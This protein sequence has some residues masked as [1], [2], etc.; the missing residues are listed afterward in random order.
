M[1]EPITTHG[2][3]GL[4]RLAAVLA[5]DPALAALVSALAE[6]ANTIEDAIQ[7]MQ[8]LRSV[9]TAG[10]SQLDDIG[11]LIGQARLS[12]EA[13]AVMRR[14]IRARILLNKSRGTV[15]DVITCLDAL[16]DPAT[17]GLIHVSE[18]HPAALAV[19]VLVTVP[20]TAAEQ[21]QVVEF[22]TRSKPAGV[23]INGIAYYTDPVFGFLA[24]PDPAV[25]PLDDGTLSPASGT[26]ADYFY[27]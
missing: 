4:A 24:D 18:S 23:G 19:A 11:S 6:R 14:K 3:D 26:F 15:D 8:E 7:D 13:D 10:D 20:L 5:Q 21:L 2:A 9:T 27:P 17:T 12:G 16:L 22:V 25:G 1:I